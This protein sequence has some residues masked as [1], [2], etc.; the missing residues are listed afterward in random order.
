M[1]AA[2]I[3]PVAIIDIDVAIDVDVAVDVGPAIGAPTDVCTTDVAPDFRSRTGPRRRPRIDARPGHRARL[4]AAT[5]ESA[6][7]E[8]TAAATTTTAALC[9]SQ[10]AH[11]QDGQQNDQHAS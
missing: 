7:P 1:T 8:T 6:T 3:P 4:E 2:I 10:I 11:G 5:P 9:Q